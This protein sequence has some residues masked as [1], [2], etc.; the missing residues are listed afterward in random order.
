MKNQSEIPGGTLFPI[1]KIIMKNCELIT[2]IL[3][4]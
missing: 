3:L 4:L 1:Y 2:F